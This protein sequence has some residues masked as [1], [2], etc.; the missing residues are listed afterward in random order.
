M[1]REIGI[2]EDETLQQTVLG[3]K[4]GFFGHVMRSDGFEKGML[5][6]YG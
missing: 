3:K 4:L 1:R 5:L 6:A 2:E